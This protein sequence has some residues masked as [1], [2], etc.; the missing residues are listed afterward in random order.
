MVS[1][2]TSIKPVSPSQIQLDKFLRDMET[3]EGAQ[4]WGD[5]AYKKAMKA[6]KTGPKATE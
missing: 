2:C 6:Q 1:I 4:K 3:E 5:G